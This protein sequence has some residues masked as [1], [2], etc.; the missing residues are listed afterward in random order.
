MKQFVPYLMVLSALVSGCSESGPP[1]GTLTGNVTYQGKPLPT[2]TITFVP[3]GEE[4]PFAYA[5][6]E[7]DGSYIAETP[8]VGSVIEV[9]SYKVMISAVKDVGPES[10][11]VPL[12]PDKYSSDQSSGLTAEISEGENTADFTL[13]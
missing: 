3:Q 2:G 1:T 12:I 13:D 6:I 9:G 8:D 4:I 5:E 11:V 7:E 10:P